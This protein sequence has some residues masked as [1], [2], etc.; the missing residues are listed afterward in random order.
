MNRKIAVV[1]G[2]TKGIGYAIARKLVEKDFYVIGTYVSDYSKEVL[3]SL[4]SDNFKLLRVDGTDS[5]ACEVFARGVLGEH[6]SIDVLVNNAGIVNDKLVLAMSGDDFK[7]VLDVNLVG[8][9]NMTKA[10]TKAFFK[11][12]QGAIVNITSVI[13]V[14]GNV[15]QANYAA[16]KAGV[17]GFSK[18]IA[19]EYASRNIRVNCIAPGF[20]KTDMTDQLSDTFKEVI[21]AKVALKRFGH[22]EDVANAVAFLVSDEASY[23]TGQVL[24][25]CGGMVI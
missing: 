4:E 6:G 9:F 23:I 24:N 17:I 16:S 13:G 1:T 5:S 15:G 25:V 21:E 18:S 20:I 11:S 12:R 2:A 10:F 8:T 19:K 3:D 22:A 14:I 7:S